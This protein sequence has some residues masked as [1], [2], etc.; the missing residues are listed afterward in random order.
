MNSKELIAEAVK[1]GDYAKFEQHL[2]QDAIDSGELTKAFANAWANKAVHTP[3]N[4]EAPAN[5]PDG[6]K[7]EKPKGR[8]GVSID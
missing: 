3:N 2:M 7:P 1:S 6:H 5:A 8:R 4:G